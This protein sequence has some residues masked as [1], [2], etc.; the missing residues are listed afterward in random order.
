MKSQELISDPQTIQHKGKKNTSYGK[1]R[2]IRA[3]KVNWER[4]A[5][6]DEKITK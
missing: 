6:T 5:Q 1:S 4:A 3:H 2:E